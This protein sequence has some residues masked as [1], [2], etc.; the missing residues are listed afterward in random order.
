M[1]L[2][3][4]TLIERLVDVHAELYEMAQEVLAEDKAR[5]IRALQFLQE[6]EAT[7]TKFLKVTEASFGREGETAMELRARLQDGSKS[8]RP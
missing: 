8:V 1:K 6:H 2:A 4:Q 3:E 5:G 7:V